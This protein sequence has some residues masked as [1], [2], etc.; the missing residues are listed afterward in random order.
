MMKIHPTFVLH[1]TIFVLSYYVSVL[2]SL[3]TSVCYFSGAV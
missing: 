1:I 3:Y 2:K